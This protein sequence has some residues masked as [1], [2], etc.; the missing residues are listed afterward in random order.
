MR[1]D[2]KI[3]RASK[4]TLMG[5]LYYLQRILAPDNDANQAVLQEIQFLVYLFH[6]TF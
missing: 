1:N 5:I 6:L 2:Q 3:Y 4:N